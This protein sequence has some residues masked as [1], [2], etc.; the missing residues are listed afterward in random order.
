MVCGTVLTHADEWSHLKILAWTDPVRLRE[1]Y[2][3]RFNSSP[4][5]MLKMKGIAGFLGG[6][7]DISWRFV[8]IHLDG[9]FNLKRQDGARSRSSLGATV[10][11]MLNGYRHCMSLIRITRVAHS[12]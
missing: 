8:E 10:G 2:D 9:A 11:D 1:E 6:L 4:T 5:Y 12:W 7:Q 3:G